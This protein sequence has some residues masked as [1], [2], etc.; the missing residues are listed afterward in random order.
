MGDPSDRTA[1]DLV[2]DIAGGVDPTPSFADGLQVQRVLAAVE[3]S[4]DTA[5][6]HDIPA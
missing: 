5:S 3:A 1:V 2:N 6:W 4:S